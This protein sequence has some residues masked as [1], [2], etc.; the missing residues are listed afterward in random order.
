[1]TVAL[2]ERAPAVRGR[3]WTAEDYATRNATLA[4]LGITLRAKG[5]QHGIEG[6]GTR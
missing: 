1:M 4:A 3:T 2:V 6:G 5:A